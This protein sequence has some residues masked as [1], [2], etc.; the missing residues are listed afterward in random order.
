MHGAEEEKGQ[1]TVNGRPDGMPG[2]L[3]TPEY[4]DPLSLPGKTMASSQSADFAPEEVETASMDRSSKEKLVN[5]IHGTTN[6]VL[7][8]GVPQPSTEPQNHA[9]ALVKDITTQLPPEIEQITFGYL[10]MSTLITRLAQATFSDLLEVINDSSASQ[11]PPSTYG[12]PLNHASP[13]VNGNSAPDVSQANVQR[14]LRILDFAQDRRADFIKVLVLSQWSR[15]AE[16][17]GKVI[18]LKVWLDQQKQTFDNAASWMAE[19]K[20][21][22]GSVK[23]PNP[24][25]DRALE[26]L[27]LTRSSRFSDLN[28]MPREVLSAR[29]ILKTLRDLNF[30]LSVRLRVHEHIPFQFRNYSVASGRVTFR[31]PDEFELDL[32][33]ADEDPASQ[34]FFIDFRFGFW[35]ASKE[36]SPGRLRDE[37]ERRVNSILTKDKFAGCYETLHQFVLTHKLTILKRQAYK[38]L[39]GPSA[40]HLWVE[41]IHRSIIIKYWV[42]RPRSKNWIEMGIKRRKGERAT[43]LEE[44]TEIPCIAIRWFRDGKEDQKS[45][46]NLKL[47]N[48]SIS[49]ILKR[50]TAMHT[51]FTFKEIATMLKEGRIY[52]ERLL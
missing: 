4:N 50:V 49:G 8:N 12:G 40:E 14:K 16:A 46:I 23:Q 28:Y 1:E 43:W 27:S 36:I 34:F 48:L 2:V 52:S 37:L 11:P 45:E 17:V 9:M 25:I 29:Q 47:G 20:R 44:A 31:V 7:S 33:I 24:D 15:Q 3:E 13:H 38:M 18:D 35:P 22:L 5:G 30:Q 32:A 10:P 26:A 51:V 42:N 21:I 39:R 6:G 19:L 41:A